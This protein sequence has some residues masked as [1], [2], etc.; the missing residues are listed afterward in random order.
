VGPET[1]SRT[2]AWIDRHRVLADLIVLVAVAGL[3]V[4]PGA[5]E[6]ADRLGTPWWWLTAAVCFVPL[7]WRRR[8]PLPVFGLVAAATIAVLAAGVRQLAGTAFAALWLALYTVAAHSSPRRA[9]VAAGVFEAWGVAAVVR[10][11]PDYA[12][13][14]GIV[15]A[16]G[17]ATAAVAI[18]VYQRTRRAY[19]AALEERADRLEHERD[20]QAR[21]A[22]ATER[23]RI[24]RE[25]HDIVT[26]SLSV[27]VALADGAAATAVGAPDRAGEAMRQVA[28]T[29]RQAIGEMRRIVG[30]LRTDDDADHGD[31]ADHRPTPGL[32]DLEEL[33][34][35]VRAT[36]LPVR[37]VV[38]GRPRLLAPGAQLAIYRIVQ[39]S[40]TNVR[41]HA[42]GASAATVTLRY[43]DDG[44]ET[45]ISD[46][47]RAPGTPD[48]GDGHGI[49]GMRERA[50]AY[51]GTV[52]A[53][54]CPGGGWLV[55]ARLSGDEEL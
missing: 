21:L 13:L 7:A 30:T 16:T 33:L 28:V 39:E 12:L 19:L 23:T 1:A 51:G 52:T 4:G 27:M 31:H 41:K 25:V 14:P 54:P 40:L 8:Y 11:A 29:G 32:G 9:L 42:A 15:L 46:D 45:E 43:A 10:W 34:D 3:T 17:T 20:Q 53:G 18:G 35:Q 37:L 55:R 24:A 38:E 6:R 36:G 48:A 50:A 47:G 5:R 49:T 44:I 26:H 22:V 2:W